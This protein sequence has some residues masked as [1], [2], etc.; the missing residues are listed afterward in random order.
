MSPPSSLG[1]SLAAPAAAEATDDVD[2]SASSLD[3]E[4]YRL[5]SIE[6]VRTPSG[7]TGR[8]WF[9]YRI[10]QGENAI[11]GYRQGSRDSVSADVE[12][13]VSGLNGRRKWA[14]NKG[15]SKSRSRAAAAQARAEA[16]AARRRAAE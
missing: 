2:E 10:A 14:K 11:T 13:I 12:S 16:A 9:V 7:C 15:E 1:G 8:D 5:L 3:V 6:A 4:R